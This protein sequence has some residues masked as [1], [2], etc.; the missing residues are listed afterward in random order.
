M[1]WHMVGYHSS[2]NTSIYGASASF[3]DGI[4]ACKKAQ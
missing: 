1:T 3:F 2:L 4:C